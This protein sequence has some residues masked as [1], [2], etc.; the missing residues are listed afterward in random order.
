MRAWWDALAVAPPPVSRSGKIFA[1][2]A[3]LAAAASRFVAISLTAWDWDEAHFVSALR[4]YDVTAHAPHPPGFPLFIGAAKLLALAGMPSFRALQ[5]I[6]VI[7]ALAI[8]PAMF[9]LAREARAPFAVALTAALFLAFFPNVWFYGGTAF[10]DVPA[11]VLAVAGCALLMRGARSDAAFIAGSAVLAISAGIRPQNLLIGTIPFVI[12]AVRRRSVRAIAI[13]AVLIVAIL[14]VSYG[15]AMHLSGGWT[16]YR[17]ALQAHEQYIMRTDSF[18]SPI[19]PP[20]HRLIDDFF[21]WPYRA[22]WINVSIALLVVIGLIVRR[23]ASLAIVAAFAPFCVFAWLFLDH[24]SASRFSIGYAPLVAMLAAEGAFA[25]CAR[26][27]TAI[28]AIVIGTMIAWTWPSLRVV[29][30]TES[31]SFAAMQSI[32]RQFTPQQA[33]IEV[34]RPM[35]AFADAFL[36][37]YTWTSIGSAVPVVSFGDARAVVYAREGVS[38]DPAAMH[39]QRAKGR[40]WWLARQ[41]YFDVSVTRVPRPQFGAGWYDEESDAGRAWRWMAN[42]ATIPLPPSIR[43]A[44]LAL[45]LHAAGNGANVTIS[46]DGR[47]LDRFVMANDLERYVTVVLRRDAPTALTIETDRVVN[48][49]R[50]GL[51]ADSRDLGLRLDGFDLQ[52]EVEPQGH[53]RLDAL[54]ILHRR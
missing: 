4:D 26:A 40:L 20:L 42:R 28:S 22:P 39:F 54:P 50:E 1:A 53:P 43:R 3:M 34:D 17:E 46:I 38:I 10:S 12:A 11:M 49:A 24:L 2:I 29:R 15:A 27:G 14:T 21:F 19:R 25:L 41:R 30:T 23:P 6:D 36:A 35:L 5:A 33:I 16:P 13:S 9:F 18:R 8:V 7:A 48:P 45:R 47:P 51:S 31:P 44:H 32:R 52:L 37:D